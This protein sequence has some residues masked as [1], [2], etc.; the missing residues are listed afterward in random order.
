MY[1]MVE[2]TIIAY[3]Y[4]KNRRFLMGEVLSREFQK[5]LSASIAVDQSNAECATPKLL[6]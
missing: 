2:K 1:A 6:L 4:L 3:F 5:T